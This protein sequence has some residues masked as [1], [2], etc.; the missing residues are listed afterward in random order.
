MDNNML[1]NEKVGVDQFRNEFV[2]FKIKMLG[3]P[4][5][6][7]PDLSAAKDWEIFQESEKRKK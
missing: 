5:S 3:G 1:K 4:S 7:K 2:D 6:A